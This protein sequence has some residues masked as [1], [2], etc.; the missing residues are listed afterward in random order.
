MKTPAEIESLLGLAAGSIVITEQA[1][2][3]L[4]SP[5]LTL[6][7]AS[8]VKLA[9]MGGAFIVP[10]WRIRAVLRRRDLLTA[11][12]NLVAQLPEPVRIVVE[13]QMRSSNFERGHQVIGQIGTALGLSSTDL[14]DIFVEAD[15]LV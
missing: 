4:F 5:P 14:D 3:R 7:Q 10:A 9:E 1:G 15:M 12:E 6:E 13:E 11:V 2:E 8:R